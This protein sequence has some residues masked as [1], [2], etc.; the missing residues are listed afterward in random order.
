MKP[1]RTR[2]AIFTVLFLL[3]FVSRQYSF[4]TA[5]NIDFFFLIIV[6]TAVCF[7]FARTMATA[8]LLGLLTDYLSGGIIGVFSFSRIL[9]SFLIFEAARMIDFRKK[10]FVFLAIFLSLLLSNVMAV[11]F[12]YHISALQPTLQILI[13]QPLSTGGLALLLVSFKSI[14]EHLNVP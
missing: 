11:F 6:H 4:L 3:Q 12:L 14:S 10:V 1:S 8:T 5:L 13:I 7:S 2:F 9:F